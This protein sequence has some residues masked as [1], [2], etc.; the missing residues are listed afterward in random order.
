RK[1]GRRVWADGDRPASYC[2]PRLE[3]LGDLRQ[4]LV[5]DGVGHHGYAPAEGRRL[6]SFPWT[7]DPQINAAQPVLLPDGN[8]FISS[9]YAAGCALVAVER[10]GETWTARPAGWEHSTRFKA[11]FNDYVL[12]EGHIYGLDEGVLCCFDP[13]TA[14][15][16]WRRGRYGYGQVLLIQDSDLLVVQSEAGDVYL[17]DASPD[18]FRERARLPALAAKTWNHPVVAQGRLLVRNGEEAACYE[19]SSGK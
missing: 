18:E 7:N 13:A 6:W 11:K 17:V 4:L 10:G 3:V 15:R 9:G 1:T 2:S 5:H 19:L 8:L 14:T 16:R 12:H